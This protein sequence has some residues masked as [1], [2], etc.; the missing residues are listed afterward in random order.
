MFKGIRDFFETWQEAV[1][2]IVI[3]IVGY[4]AY[5]LRERSRKRRELIE[6]LEKIAENLGN[7]KLDRIEQIITRNSGY[8]EKL[9]QDICEIKDKMT[10][11]EAGAVIMRLLSD[12]AIFV[13]DEQGRLIDANPAMCRLFGASK[14]QLLGYGILQFIIPK[15]RDKAR[16]DLISSV[17]NDR[18]VT[19]HYRIFHG[20]T[21]EIV[22]I[23]YRM[24]IFRNSKNEI[25]QIIGKCYECS[26]D[27]N[28]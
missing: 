9:G 15:D 5:R 25:L 10:S 23:E 19:N 8:N 28:N 7:G 13:A 16:D 22:C 6:R 1:M 17:N 26:N 3:P 18:D 11:L 27:L 20:M 4:I 21:E 24:F 14:N 12:S 2:A